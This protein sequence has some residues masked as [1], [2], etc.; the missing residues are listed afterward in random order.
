MDILGNPGHDQEVFIR[1]QTQ[2]TQY[3]EYPTTS[4]AE[5][6]CISRNTIGKQMREST[7]DLHYG[8]YRLGLSMMASKIEPCHP[9]DISVENPTNLGKSLIVKVEP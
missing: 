8:Q 3:L 2:S 5:H 1:M 6:C 7:I 4:M 9:S